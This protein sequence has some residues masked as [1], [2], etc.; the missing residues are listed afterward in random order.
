[1]TPITETRNQR[2]QPAPRS[3]LDSAKKTL[4]EI[5]WSFLL[6]IWLGSAI[7][8][9]LLALILTNPFIFIDELWYW[10]IARTFHRTGQF[11]LL[12]HDIY[13]PSRLY[14]VLLSA[15]FVFREPFT[16]Y[17]AAKMIN[18]LLI[19]SVVFPVY[20]L[21]RELLGKK[22]CAAALLLSVAIAGGAYSGTIMPENLFYP[23][24][25]LSFWLAYRVL[26]GLRARDG[27]LSGIAFSVSYFIK[28]HIMILALSYS[29]CV[30]LFGV[31]EVL[32]RRHHPAGRTLG[33]RDAFPLA[34][35]LI[36]LA[37]TLG[38]V[39]VSSPGV[40]FA[41]RIMGGYYATVV[42]ASGVRAHTEHLGAALLGLLLALSIST[43]FLPVFGLPIAAAKLRQLSADRFWFCVLTLATF[44]CLVG[45]ITR[46]TLLNDPAI[47]VHERYIFVISPC[48]FICYLLFWREW[49]RRSLAWP[50]WEFF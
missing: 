38:V 34:L 49:Q 19:C 26:A 9:F 41:S 4:L 23:A 15:A 25:M 35:P 16:S 40:S 18:A 32:Q 3:T 42:Q 43:A 11:L 44:A 2:I 20:L 37:L 6:S 28:P 39:F 46:F 13:I 50:S 12:D 27:L 8:R 31:R 36:L 29:L 47:R 45:V 1:M 10:Q 7:L 24:F 48:L 22:E 17:V 14:S 33:W 5:P 30:G 21:A